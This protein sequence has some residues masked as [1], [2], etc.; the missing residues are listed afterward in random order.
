MRL[1]PSTHALR[2]RLEW[3]DH[4]CDLDLTWA[5]GDADAWLGRL[6]WCPHEKGTKVVLKFAPS[7][8]YDHVCKLR[9]VGIEKPTKKNWLTDSVV[10]VMMLW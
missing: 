10:D 7:V 9:L 6:Q 5:P 8:E 4:E 1:T 3:Q 2:R